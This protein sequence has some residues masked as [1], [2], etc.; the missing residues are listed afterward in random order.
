[1]LAKIKNMF[2]KK[3]ENKFEKLMNCID[4]IFIN[5]NNIVIKLNKNLIVHSEGHQFFVSNGDVV[6]K[7]NYLH[8]NP[9]NEIVDDLKCGKGNKALKI[10]HSQNSKMGFVS[11]E[12]LKYG[13][14][15]IE[16]E[17]AGEEH[18]VNCK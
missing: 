13:Q 15:I 2:L 1:M 11:N 10:I 12:A 3:K 8:L 14:E 6:I 9:T 17:N 5:Q 4:D 7:S 16:E 18:C